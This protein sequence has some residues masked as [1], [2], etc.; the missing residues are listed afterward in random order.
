MAGDRDDKSGGE[1]ADAELQ[2]RLDALGK[3]LAGETPEE[4]EAGRPPDG[5]MGQAMGQGMRAMGE[6]V[7]AVGV[8][9]LIGWQ[10]DE[11]LH[12]SPAALLVFLALGTAAGF[13]NVYRLAAKP[14]TGPRN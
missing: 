6:F 8:S 2:A 10:L 7:G 5:A 1:P 4:P 3:R 12:S 9:A 14:T 11:W 13:Y